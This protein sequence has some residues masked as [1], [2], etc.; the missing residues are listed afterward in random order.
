MPMAGDGCCPPGATPATDS[1]C[2]GRCGDGTLTPPEA[3]DDGNTTPGDGCSATCT[4]EPRSFRTTT[5]TIQEP[6]FFYI[7]DITS[8]VNTE[9]RT[10]LTTD[11]DMPVDGIVDLSPVIHFSPF[12]QSAMTNPLSV[13]F[14]DCTMPLSSTRCMGSGMPTAATAT[15]RTMGTCLAPVA[16]TFPTGRGINSPAAPCFSSDPVPMLTIDL[17]G[18]I[19]RLRNAQVGGQYVGT[20]ATRLSTGLIMGFLTEADAM[21]TTLPPD[22]AIVGGRT[23]ASLLRARDR[24]MLADGTLGWWFYLNYTGDLVPYT[25]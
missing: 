12:D 21:A 10:A 22:I 14:A 18:T 8:N 4:R 20:P 25:P 9:L 17:G 5:L 3:C 2:T 15:N 11:G 1:D 7:V 13:D 16:G 24:D 19:I 6:H 23:I